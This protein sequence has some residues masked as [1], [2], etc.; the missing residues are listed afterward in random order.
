[1]GGCDAVIHL[2][3]IIREFPKQGITFEKL[4]V[5]ATE[6][7]INTAKKNGIERFL[8]MSAL[9]AGPS[10]RSQYHKTK[11]QAEEHL[12]PSGLNYTIFQPSVIYGP[13]DQFVNM[14]ARMVR[15]NPITPLIGGGY[16]RLQPIALENV[17][18]GFL[19]AL[20]EKRTS[21]RTYKVGGPEA[22]TFKEI[23]NTIKDIL[24]IRRPNV[25]IPMIFIKPMV[26]LMERFP[27]F[28]L[29]SDQLIMLKED[30]TCDPT[31]YFQH[32]KI[33]PIR[34]REGIFHFLRG[35]I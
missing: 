6:D 10:A 9:G 21:Y 34:F 17:S 18:Q 27:F 1:M 2:V 4:H 3:G 24:G 12:R 30:N 28:P 29:T 7:L 25:R 15:R 13:G 32:M 23:L 22:L 11:Y 20:R 14:L 16:N 35:N 31:L 33:N 8:Q 19:M 5:K 26:R